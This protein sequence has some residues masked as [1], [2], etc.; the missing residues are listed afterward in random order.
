MRLITILI[1]LAG[2]AV[3]IATIFHEGARQILWIL[4]LAGWPILLLAPL[5]VA[6]IG[7]DA[8][9][10]EQLL[11]G[12]D[13]RPGL[14]FL[15]WAAVI[16]DSIDAL[17]PVVRVGGDFAGIDMLCA[18]GIALPASAASVVAEVVI[19]LIAQALFT[20]IGT[21]LLLA[22]GKPMPWIA[23]AVAGAMALSIPFALGVIAVQRHVRVFGGLGRTVH[24]LFRLRLGAVEKVGRIDDELATLYRRYGILALSCLWELA[25][26]IVTGAEV[27][28]ALALM[29]HPVPPADALV[30]ESFWQALRSI[31]FVVPAALGVQ[32]LGLVAF[33]SLVGL[34]P[35]VSLALS[36]A[37]RLRDVTVGVP[38]L[39][40]WLWFQARYL[41]HD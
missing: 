3:S 4:S 27:W 33:G 1:T 26:L 35:D 11:S 34:A 31:A 8:K 6:A 5:H 36:L 37:K 12:Y 30:I 22:G 32:E 25:G 14:T 15:T 38:A 39:L 40:S 24:Y 19:T 17:L 10:W 28:L 29:G 7:L 13:R 2:I 20:L 23:S 18:R 41:R 9:G 16:R 21:V